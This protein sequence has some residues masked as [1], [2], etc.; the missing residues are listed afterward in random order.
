MMQKNNEKMPHS[1]SCIWWTKPRPMKRETHATH[2]HNATTIHIFLTKKS[3]VRKHWEELLMVCDACASVSVCVSL[4]RHKCVNLCAFSQ[5]YQWFRKRAGINEIL[6]IESREV[7][8]ISRILRLCHNKIYAAIF[9][10]LIAMKYLWNWNW[11]LFSF[12]EADA[13]VQWF[14]QSEMHAKCFIIYL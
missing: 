3:L 7:I 14:V 2:A 10:M 13:W 11:F 4:C 9:R 5:M 6:C 1:D 12:F 8:K